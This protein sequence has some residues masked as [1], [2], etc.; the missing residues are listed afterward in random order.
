MAELAEFSRGTMGRA[1]KWRL[2]VE[3]LAGRRARRGEGRATLNR[4]KEGVDSMKRKMRNREEMAEAV[5]W[6]VECIAGRMYMQ[7][8]LDGMD[9]QRMRGMWMQ[10]MVGAWRVQ[11]YAAG[12]LDGARAARKGRL[13]AARSN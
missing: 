10:R 13:P 8:F 4:G 5:R 1:A 2:A 12:F 3:P 9:H 11:A 7:G 6:V